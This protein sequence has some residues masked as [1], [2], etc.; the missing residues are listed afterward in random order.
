MSTHSPEPW[1]IQDD[2]WSVR[3]ELIGADSGFIADYPLDVCRLAVDFRRIVACVNACANIPPETIGSIASLEEFC[4]AYLRSKGYAISDPHE[5][6]NPA[7][8]QFGRKRD[9]VKEKRPKQPPG[10]GIVGFFGTS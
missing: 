7:V 6:G 4:M 10:V 5:P 9:G 2:R 8:V 3:G 1:I